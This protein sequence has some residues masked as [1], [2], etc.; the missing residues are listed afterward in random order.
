MNFVCEIER[1]ASIKLHSPRFT[2][3][4]SITA[5]SLEDAATHVWAILLGLPRET[6]QTL[7]AVI[8]PD[9]WGGPNLRRRCKLT[10]V[11]DYRQEV[12]A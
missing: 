6:D 5:A 7:T 4:Q 9:D 11:G 3:S 10:L 2:T 8:V 1:D 12:H